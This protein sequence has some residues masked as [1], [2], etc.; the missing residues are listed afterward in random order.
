MYEGGASRFNVEAT[1]AELYEFARPSFT[2]EEI[3]SHQVSPFT[4]EDEYLKALWQ[5]E[6]AAGTPFCIESE[7]ND[8]RDPVK[9]KLWRILREGNDNRGPGY[10]Q[11]TY[12]TLRQSDKMPL[13]TWFIHTFKVQTKLSIIYLPY[14]L[15]FVSYIPKP[16]AS[17]T[18]DLK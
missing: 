3:E 5:N 16:G 1:T 14:K 2:G 10:D 11:L 13:I 9:K 8:E 15:R 18:Q 12:R 4:R 7:E 6:E 17:N